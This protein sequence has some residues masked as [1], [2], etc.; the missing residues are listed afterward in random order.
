MDNLKQLIAATVSQTEVRLEGR[1]AN[2]DGKIEMLHL[3]MQEGFAGVSEAIED[4]QSRYDA[5]H[6]NLDKRV[7]K[8]EAKAA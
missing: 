2:L 8:L 1:L 4:T 7:A 5:Q 6:A 3:E